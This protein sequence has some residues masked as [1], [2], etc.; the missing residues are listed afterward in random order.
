M[1]SIDYMKD[2]TVREYYHRWELNPTISGQNRLDFYKFVKA[3]FKV[4]TRLDIDYLKPA[5]YDSFHEQYDEKRYDEF[6]HRVV[7]LFEHL[8]DFQ[9]T[10]LP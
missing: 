7:I 2:A 10:S 3:C 8:R 1:S 4:D 6:I 9:N 5:L